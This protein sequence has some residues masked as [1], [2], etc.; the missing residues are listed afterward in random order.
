MSR[1]IGQSPDGPGP[2][3]T[4]AILN[5]GQDQADLVILSQAMIFPRTVHLETGS[6]E[7]H[8]DE[9]TSHLTDAVRYA[10]YSLQLGKVHRLYVTGL[11]VDSTTLLHHL[12]T[13]TGLDVELWNPLERLTL[14]LRSAWRSV[15]ALRAMPTALTSCLGLALHPGAP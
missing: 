5:L 2:E 6:W 14:R 13:H 9:L 3:E 7:D 10:Q 8:P 11:V 4:L 15:D 1:L 12:V